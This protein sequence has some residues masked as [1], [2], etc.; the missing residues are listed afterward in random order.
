MCATRAGAS[1]LLLLALWLAALGALAQQVTE[2]RVIP[3]GVYDRAG[4]FVEGLKPEQIRVKGVRGAAVRRLVRDTS[5]RRIILLLDIS[6]SMS[7]EKKGE[8]ATKMAKELLSALQPDDWVALH[9]FAKEHEVLLP[10][11]RDF[12]A[13]RQQLNALPEPDTKPAKEAYGYLTVLAEALANILAEEQSDSRFGDTVLLVSDGEEIQPGKV[14]LRKLKPRLA[15][16]G[17]RIFLLR[18]AQPSLVWQRELAGGT[19]AEYRR[20]GR[21]FFEFWHDMENLARESGGAT[22]DPWDSVVVMA[23]RLRLDPKHINAVARAAY[24][25]VRHVYRLDFELS[26]PLRKRRKLKLEVLNEQ[27]R[28]VKKLNLLYPRYLTPLPARP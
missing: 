22:L 7:R 4:R 20:W 12:E 27:G 28:R 19:V 26:E 17:L 25:L 21:T 8:Y 3:L 13:I 6:G 11:T 15:G 18:V 5:P 1:F 10:F 9:V 16:A 24:Q 23:G 2:T 14:R